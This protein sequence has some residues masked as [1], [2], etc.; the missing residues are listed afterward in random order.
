MSDKQK[1]TELTEFAMF[2][3]ETVKKQK[4]QLQKNKYK[5]KSKVNELKQKCS[6]I[7]ADNDTE[8]STLEDELKEKQKKNL[9]VGNNY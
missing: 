4:H 6:E 5:I 1:Q 7:K 9:S 3:T 8:K 2:E